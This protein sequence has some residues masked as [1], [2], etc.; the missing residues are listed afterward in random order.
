MEEFR[1]E[2]HAGP[3]L[4]FV[5][6]LAHK[7]LGNIPMRMLHVRPKLKLDSANFKVGLGRDI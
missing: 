5:L 3:F 1:K 4:E 7:L 6:V 2:R